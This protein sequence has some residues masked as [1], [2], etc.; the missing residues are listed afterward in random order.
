MKDDLIGKLRNII[1]LGT[2]LSEDNVRSFMVLARKLL[3]AESGLSGNNY[4]VLRL[5]SNWAVHTKITS[6]NTGLRILSK[7]NDALVSVK[8]GASSEIIERTISDAVGIDALK[9]EISNFIIEYSINKDF[10]KELLIWATFLIHLLEIIR[11]VPL[12]FPPLSELK[13]SQ[14]RIYESIASNPIKPGAGVISLELKSIPNIAVGVNES[15]NRLCLLIVTEDTTS[16]VVSF[17]TGL[18]NP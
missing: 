13:D 9:L 18:I 14:R 16:L 8:N 17:R 3:D 4:L 5:F 11:D 2:D 12:S 7:V 1:N 10:T 6:S 15:G